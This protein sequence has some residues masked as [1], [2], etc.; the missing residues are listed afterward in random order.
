MKTRIASILLL[1]ICL[2]AG[3]AIQYIDY[4]TVQAPAPYTNLLNMTIPG[5]TTNNTVTIITT[6]SIVGDPLPTAA[7]KINGD[8]DW[9][10]T[11]GTPG[12]SNVVLNYG[13]TLYQPL[14]AN[15]TQWSALSTNVLTNAVSGGGGTNV[16]LGGVVGGPSGA[17]YFTTAG[18]N[19]MLSIAGYPNTNLVTQQN[20]NILTNASFEQSNILITATAINASIPIMTS[21]NTPSGFAYSSGAYSGYPA[22]IA[23]SNVLNLTTTAWIPSGSFPAWLA[24][25]FP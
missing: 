12:S 4:S 8:F 1:L 21:S 15:L 25:E 3:A 13:G 22:W 6:N 9:L 18:S 20:L 5:V 19:Y 23:F 2:T 10:D 16:T 7:A 24:Y 11:N 14:S 17:N